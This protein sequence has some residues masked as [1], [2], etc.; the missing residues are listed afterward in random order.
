MK[1]EKLRPKTWFDQKLKDKNILE[2]DLALMFSVHNTKRKL[3]CQS[4]GPYRVVEIT[5]QGAVCIATLDGVIM[6]GYINESKLKRSYGL[7]TLQTLQAIHRDQE[8]K[9]E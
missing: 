7:L 4:M 2:G 8:R 3:K 1:V 6:D 9:K 5:P